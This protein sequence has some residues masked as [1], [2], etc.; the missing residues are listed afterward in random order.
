MADRVIPSCKEL[1]NN[2]G[3]KNTEKIIDRPNPN[4]KFSKRAPSKANDSTLFN[5]EGP[6]LTPR[7]GRRPPTTEQRQPEP[8]PQ[9]GS[10]IRVSR[11]EDIITERARQREL[12][13]RPHKRRPSPSA[14]R[15]ATPSE[16]A[17]EASSAVP[18]ITG[19]GMLAK[20]GKTH[21]GKKNSQTAKESGAAAASL[22]ATSS[23]RFRSSPR[24]EKAVTNV[25]VPDTL[26]NSE[27]SIKIQR[28]S[29][30]P[31]R[32][33]SLC[34]VLGPDPSRRAPPEYKVRAPFFRDE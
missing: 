28:F 13:P 19:N 30:R 18:F 9:R 10:G 17:S 34:G 26:P 22:A 12:N 11:Y 27:P 25:T 6:L 8:S 21:L 14:E 24:T 23:A 4:S 15:S 7:L 29:A 3:F 31:L 32:E 5:T 33:P 16:C 2:T 20:G 1:P